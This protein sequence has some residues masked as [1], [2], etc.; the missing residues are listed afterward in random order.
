MTT[1]ELTITPQSTP[2]G[3]VVHLTGQADVLNSGR[4]VEALCGLVPIGVTKLLIDCSR[5]AY[6]DSMALRAFVVVAKVLRNRNGW[7]TLIH[8]REAVLR[9]LTITGADTYM[10]IQQ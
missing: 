3:T 5:L 9:M 4:L 2:A 8:P 10:R 7:L 6:I 1:P